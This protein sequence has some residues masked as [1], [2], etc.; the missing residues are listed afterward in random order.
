MSG[1]TG[2]TWPQPRAATIAAYHDGE[3]DPLS[4]LRDELHAQGF[5]TGRGGRVT[6]PHRMRRHARRMRRYGLQPMVVINCG[7]RLP[8]LVVV[9]LGRWPGGTAPN[10]PRCH[11][12]PLPRWPHGC[13]TPRTR[14]G[15]P[16]PPAPPL[17]P[18]RPTAWRAARLG[19]ATRAERMLRRPSPR[20]GRSWLAAATASAL[21]RPLPWSS[22][23]AACVLAV[24]WWAHRRRRARVRVER[25]AR[26]LAGD[27]RR[28]SGWPAP[29]S[30]QPWWTCGAGGPGSRL[31]RGQTI[32]DVIAKLPAIE[33]GLG[34]FRGAARVYPDPR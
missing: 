5:G 9:M 14:T 4:Y 17:P 33:S 26:R 3:P 22:W 8:D 11:R 2:P 15:G 28:R 23:S 18:A 24:P 19:L 21:A 20:P 27:R 25:T 31:A 16:R 30:C 6:R 32:T 10:S 1:S 12:R 29:G 34:T 13:C 7:D